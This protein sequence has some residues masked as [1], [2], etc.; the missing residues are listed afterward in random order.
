[1]SRKRQQQQSDEMRGR[2]LSIA[3]R[4]LAEEGPDALSVRRIAGEMEYSAASLYHYF[5]DKDSILHCLLMEGYQRILASIRKPERGLPADETIKASMK[6]Y[7]TG[8]L[9]WPAEYRALM[10]SS[11]PEILSVTA[12]LGED[13]CE[14]RE[15]FRMFASAIE[16]GIASGIFAPCDPVLTA[17]ALWCSMFGLATR[18]IIEGAVS[19]ERQDALINRQIELLVKGIML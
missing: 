16:E 6:Y 9:E 1:M 13:V 5:K 17:Q 8:V 14:I 4:I 3:R 11:K 15:S 12:V 2:I 10:L 7:I 19:D 18:L